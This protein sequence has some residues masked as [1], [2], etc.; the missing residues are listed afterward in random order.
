M[1]NTKKV[2]VS[3]KLTLTS[4]SVA[5]RARDS[6]L[7]QSPDRVCVNSVIPLLMFTRIDS[8]RRQLR[9]ASSPRPRVLAAPATTR[10]PPRA[11]RTMKNVFIHHSPSRTRSRDRAP[12]RF[13]PSTDA[14]RVRM[15]RLFVSNR[16]LVRGTDDVAIARRARTHDERLFFI[17][18]FRGRGS[19]ARAKPTSVAS[20][21]ATVGV[22]CAVIRRGFRSRLKS[23]FFDRS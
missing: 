2:L 9:I 17:L 8:S 21:S 7:R 5:A 23:P 6:R 11:P 3:K 4:S 14:S 1:K 22:R 12:R 10:R 13:A 18:S 15:R 19:S 16:R 20:R